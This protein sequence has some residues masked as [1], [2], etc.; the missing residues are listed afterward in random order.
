MNLRDLQLKFGGEIIGEVLQP[1]GAVGTLERAGD[2]HITFLANPKYRSALASSLAGAVILSPKDRDATDKPRI[3]TDNPYA[4][5]AR[6]AQ[7][8]S[9]RLTHA[10]DVHAL[11]VVDPSA[12]IAASAS[13]AEFVSI[14]ANAV[15]GDGVRIG[16]G[17]VIGENVVIGDASE[18]VARVTM[19]ANCEIGKRALIHAG[20]VIG[21]DGF[22]FAK[23]NE[24]ANGAWLKIPQ[25]GRV[26]IGDDCEIGANTTIDR[27]AIE[28]TIV[29]DGVKIDNQV[30]VGHNCVIGNHTLICGCTGI[31]GSTIIGERVTIGGAVSITGHL[32]ICD[33]AVLSANAFVTKSITEPGMYSAGFP[34]M[35]HREWLKNAAQLRHLDEMANK[36]KK[37]GSQHD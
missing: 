21:A 24:N 35:P 15:I 18:L 37:L 6:V 7:L 2:T 23:D 31:A 28:D 36:L 17:C 30:Q 9:P 14:G 5:F 8:F 11:A 25:T 20:V 10:V 32:S 27:G 29:G 12:R 1:I 13:I 19:Y 3:I 26:V 4:Y 34:L 16:A 22:G 33:D